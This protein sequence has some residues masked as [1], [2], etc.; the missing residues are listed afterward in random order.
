MPPLL[1]LISSALLALGGAEATVVGV[2]DGDTVRLRRDGERVA[3]R[4]ACIDA[5]ELR[6]RPRGAAARWQLREL[7][8][9]GR[10]HV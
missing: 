10:A 5:P 3:V 8:Q 4:L 6:Q 2:H 9:I 7:L 1:A